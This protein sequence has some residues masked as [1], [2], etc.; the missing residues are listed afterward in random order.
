MHTDPPTYVLPNLHAIPYTVVDDVNELFLDVSMAVLDTISNIDKLD[1]ITFQLF[2]NCSFEGE[3]EQHKP[4]NMRDALKR[5]KNHAMKFDKRARMYYCQTPDG[6][7]ELAALWKPDSS[8]LA[9]AK[10]WLGRHIHAFAHLR[11]NLL[12]PIHPSTH[13]SIY[14]FTLTHSLTRHLNHSIT[15]RVFNSQTYSAPCPA[16]GL[17]T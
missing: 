10:A 4:T 2:E 3:T 5:V 1:M 12:T 15:A 13:P 8:L 14:P 6:H 9:Q 7:Y 11:T 17:R 16:P